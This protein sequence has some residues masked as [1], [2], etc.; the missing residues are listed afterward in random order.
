MPATEEVRDE[1]SK[2]GA[3]HMRQCGAKAAPNAVQVHVDDL[4]PGP[5]IEIFQLHLARDAGI[6]DD[7]VHAAEF[8]HR[9]RYEGANIGILG[10]IHFGD[11]NPACPLFLPLCARARYR[12][13]Q[14]DTRRVRDPPQPRRIFVR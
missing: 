6:G 11:H 10:H 7:D 1:P 13:H 2:A 12:A 9:L 8:L 3:L 4:V 5:V 14:A